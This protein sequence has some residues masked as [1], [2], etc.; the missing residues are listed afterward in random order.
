MLVFFT[1]IEHIPD[2]PP[3]PGPFLSL[4]LPSVPH[5]PSVVESSL[6]STR[7]QTHSPEAG[8]G[9]PE[10]QLYGEQR[11]S[12]FDPLRLKVAPRSAGTPWTMW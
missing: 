3:S 7:N 6:D 4:P 5:D 9:T 11:I 2:E 12:H 10:T 8:F 1:L